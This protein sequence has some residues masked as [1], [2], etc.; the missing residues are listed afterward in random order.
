MMKYATITLCAIVVSLLSACEM[1]K[2][3]TGLA[4]FKFVG[5]E[6]YV[7]QTTGSDGSQAFGPFGVPTDYV[8]FKQKSKDGTVGELTTVC[9]R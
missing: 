9:E 4:E 1:P 3:D 2:M 8:V 7:C 5:F 6:N